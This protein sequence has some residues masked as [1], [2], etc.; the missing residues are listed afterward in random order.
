MTHTGI[1][2][3]DISTNLSV[4]K[5]SR[6]YNVRGIYMT[7]TGISHND[8][9][10]NLSVK[11]GSRYYNVRGIYMTRTGIKPKGTALNTDDI[12]NETEMV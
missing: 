5:G 9:R 4:K 7:H 1:S 3:N 8:I 2:H 10:T 6:Y 11:K 12:T